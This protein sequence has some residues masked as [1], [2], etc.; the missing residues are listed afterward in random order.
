MEVEITK[1]FSPDTRVP[2]CRQCKRSEAQKQ[3]EE[4]E[5]FDLKKTQNCGYQCSGYVSK[6]QEKALF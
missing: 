2:M 6:R 1:C 5:T 4:F 3:G